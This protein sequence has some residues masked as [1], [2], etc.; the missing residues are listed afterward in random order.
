M[1]IV[2]QKAIAVFKHGELSLAWECPFCGDQNERSY[3]KVPSLVLFPSQ[4]PSF[5]HGC[6]KGYAI[7]IR[8]KL[9][10]VVTPEMKQ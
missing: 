5:C 7:E 2:V 4:I 1:K 9:T 8:Q 10:G 6:Q 3:S